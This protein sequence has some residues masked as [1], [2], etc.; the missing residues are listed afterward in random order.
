MTGSDP[1]S[2]PRILTNL[3]DGQ[4]EVPADGDQRVE[5]GHGAVDARAGVPRHEAG[6]QPRQLA[7]LLLMLGGGVGNFQERSGHSPVG[8]KLIRFAIAMT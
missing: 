2:N 8:M 5:A 6:H 1:A 3:G 7:V 4:G